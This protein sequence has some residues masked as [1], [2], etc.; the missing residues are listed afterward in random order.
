MAVVDQMDELLPSA[1][2]LTRDCPP[3][4]RRRGA[5]GAAQDR[6]GSDPCVSALDDRTYADDDAPEPREEFDTAEL[7]A[8]LVFNQ[9]QPRTTRRSSLRPSC[10]RSSTH[11]TPTVGNAAAPRRPPRRRSPLRPPVGRWLVLTGAAGKPT[12]GHTG[13][14]HEGNAARTRSPTDSGSPTTTSASARSSVHR[15]SKP[16]AS[17]ARSSWP[18]PNPASRSCPTSST[19]PA[20]AQRRQRHPR[21]RDRRAPRA[22][23]RRPHH[24]D[25]PSRRTTPTRGAHLAGVPRAS[26]CRR[27]V[28]R[29]RATRR[30]LRLTGL[31]VEQSSSS[32]GARRERQ[33]DVHRHDP[34]RPA[35]RLRAA[36]AG[37]DVPRAPRRASPTT[38]PAS[39]R[40][41]G[42]RRRDRRRT[43]AQRGA[44]QEHDRRRHDH[45][46]L[47]ARRVVRVPAQFTPL[48]ATN[49]KPEITG[50]DLAI[51]RRIRLVPFTVTIPRRARPDLAAKLRAE[52]PGILTWAV[53]GCLAWQRTGSTPP[54]PSPPPPPTTATKWTFS[55]LSSPT[56][57]L[58]AETARAKSKRPLQPASA[59]GSRRTDNRARS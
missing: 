14:A 46:A 4:I 15:A 39:G 30:R 54:T 56:A 24:P 43:P 58:V 32:S 8:A 17:A 11:T 37:R 3:P 2:P 38:S 52:L 19:R 55:A 57:A 23:P 36:G 49:H 28:R 34:A 10:S 51:W 48:L 45:R 35:R 22:Q 27:R 47:H 40:P 20:A 42:R 26:P 6:P 5:R 1:H 18:S 13:R 41:H 7:D 59:S 9:R 53:E 12:T 50:T 29:V 21:P 31:T 33:D 25:H 44:G 16:A